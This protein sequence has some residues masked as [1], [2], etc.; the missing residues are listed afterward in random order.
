MQII[1]QQKVED[2]F[3]GSSVYQY[4]FDN[5][6]TK[7]DIQRLSQLGPLEY[8]PEFPRPFFRMRCSSGF[9]VKG[10]ERECSCRITF[11]RKGKEAEQ[12]ALERFFD[13]Q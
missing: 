5:V 6:W 3:D 2:C 10:V 11:S 1:K 12:Q 9:E 8:F 4:H 13:A 7:N